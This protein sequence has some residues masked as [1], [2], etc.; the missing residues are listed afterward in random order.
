VGIERADGHWL[1]VGGPVPR[2]SAGITLGRLVIV[3]ERAGSDRLL[4]HELVHV[5]Q[6]ERMGFVRFV[7]RYVSHYLRWRVRGYPHDGAYR[8]IPQE[9]EA[10]WLE[11]QPDQASAEESVTA[12]H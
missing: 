10:Y 6:F 1:W 7:I 12:H 8:R 9:V 3:R 5:R 11:R 4:R 2:G